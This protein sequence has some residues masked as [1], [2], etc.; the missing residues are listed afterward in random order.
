M[1]REGIRSILERDPDLELIGEASDGRELLEF[2]TK[3]V[4]DLIILDISMPHL[5]GLEAL[6]KIKADFP[7]VKVLILTMHKS[8]EFMLRAF[9]AKAD[10]YLLKTNA[11]D[12]LFTAIEEIRKG[13]KYISKL[14]SDQIVDLLSCGHLAPE[15]KLSSREKVVLQLF[16]QGKTTK[17]IAEHL[18][19]SI[20]TV[21]NYLFKIRK[22][23][24]VN[25][26]VGLLNYALKKQDA[27]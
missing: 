1:V 18:S 24:D 7:K 14:M 21:Y 15:E 17:Q 19:V 12:D 23:L 9:L 27:P 2:L 5:E 10:G 8:R 6:E 25:T 20:P 4:P 16:S 3:S 13:G 26:N 11:H 22:K